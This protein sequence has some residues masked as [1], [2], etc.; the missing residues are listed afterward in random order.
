MNKGSQQEVF[1]ALKEER[2]YQDNLSPERTDNH[3][4][5]VAEE[6]VLMKTY[7]ERAFVAWTDNPGD[8]QAL[9]VIR[10][11][12]GMAVRCMENNGVVRRLK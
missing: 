7:L 5:T 8:E 12:G 3:Y 6:L 11:V 2:V 10:K 1:E 9:D 4:R